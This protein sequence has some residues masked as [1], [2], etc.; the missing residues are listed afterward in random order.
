MDQK[1]CSSHDGKA[2]M[3]PQLT[4]KARN[5]EHNLGIKMGILSDCSPQQVKTGFFS[6]GG[7]NSVSDLASKMLISLTQ[8]CTLTSYLL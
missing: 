6:I 2:G 4:M 5:E 3:S 8:S 7:H 1:F